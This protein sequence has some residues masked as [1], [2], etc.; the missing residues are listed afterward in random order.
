MGAPDAHSQNQPMTDLSPPTFT[1]AAALFVFDEDMRITTW[2]HGAE[3]LTGI[4]AEEA[5]GRPCWDVV[6]GHDDAG[7]IVCHK[8]CSRSRLVREGRCVPAAELH[9]RTRAG[10]RRVS[11]ETI[12]AVAENGTAYLHVMRDAPA[13]PPAP[14]PAAGP[15]PR[16][17]PR[18]HEILGLLADGQPVK[19]VAVRLGLTETT[20]RNHVRML[21]LELGVHSQLE[22]VARGRAFALI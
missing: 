14:E 5:V 13:P 17:T 16:L 12:A 21:F 15:P 3:E 2:N 20:V 18:Q 7:G 6:A 9:A 22:A 11:L 10:R 8:G 19:R 1:T 4:P